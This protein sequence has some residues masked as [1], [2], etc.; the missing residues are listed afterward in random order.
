MFAKELEHE[1]G[2]DWG[3]RINRCKQ[4]YIGWINKVLLYRPYIFNILPLNHNEK[5]YENVYVYIYI[6]ESL[7][8][9]VKI[10]TL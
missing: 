4:L 3:F 9:T 5:V 10:N 1:R 6:K 7:C 8:C 2:M